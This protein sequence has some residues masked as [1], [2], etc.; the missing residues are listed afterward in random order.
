[1]CAE[2]ERRHY[3]VFSGFVV[4]G[5]NNGQGSSREHAATVP[6]FLG[7]RA[8]LARSFA[9][10]HRQNLLNFAVLALTFVD[11]ADYDRI[12]P[13]DVLTVEAAVAQLRRSE[14]MD[15]RNETRQETYPVRHGFTARQVE[16]VLQ[17]SLLDAFRHQQ[18]A[19]S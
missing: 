10:I 9:R 11:A 13:G 2:V 3:L 7:L 8:V 1:V 18:P 16:I 6:R 4:G 17:R 19:R 15:V 14:T 5:W 12:E